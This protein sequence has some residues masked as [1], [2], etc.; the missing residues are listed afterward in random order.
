M[1]YLLGESS[2]VRGSKRLVLGA[3]FL[4]P[5]GVIPCIVVFLSV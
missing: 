4:V 3:V 1:S 2:L 5:S